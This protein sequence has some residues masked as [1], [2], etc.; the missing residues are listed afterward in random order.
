METANPIEGALYLT[1]AKRPYGILK[2]LKV[3]DEIVH[4][5]LYK[6]KYEEIPTKVDPSSLV[7]GTINDTDGFGIAH[8]P[9]SHASFLSWGPQFL[10]HC[11]VLPEELD[12]YQIWKE[13]KGGV[14]G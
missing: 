6:N 8:L 9:L 7:F 3:E 11:L 14:W 12:G 1:T 10:Q 2:V 4:I 13:S 5:A